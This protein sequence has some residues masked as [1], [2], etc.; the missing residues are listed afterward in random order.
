MNGCK[1][2]QK[3]LI[4]DVFGELD[5]D[6]LPDWAAHM[7]TCPGCRAE[8]ERL[9]RLMDQVKTTAKPEPLTEHEAARMRA[10]LHWTL[11]NA[12]RASRLKEKIPVRYR[13]LFRPAWAA[14]ILLGLV[15]AV[16][17]VPWKQAF[18]TPPMDADNTAPTSTAMV[19]AQDQEV[20]ENLDF[21]KDLDTIRKLVH[22]VD[23]NDNEGTPSDNADTPQSPV[24]SDL[25]T[26]SYA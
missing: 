11:N 3:A 2:Y 17:G 14:G 13:F 10:R 9:R 6:E 1:D 24:S 8:R 4:L 26:E 12:D 20:L 18:F 23:Q 19:P 21:L 16:G 5:P 15:L 7:A 22:V 25:G